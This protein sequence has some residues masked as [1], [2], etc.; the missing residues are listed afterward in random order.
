MEFL[1]DFASILALIGAV[2]ATGIFFVS[3]RSYLENWRSDYE[4]CKRE[5]CKDMAITKSN[6]YE[7]RNHMEKSDIHLTYMKKISEDS[8]AAVKEMSHVLDRLSQILESI[9]KKVDSWGTK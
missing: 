4:S 8:V 5:S 3:L 7:I 6:T 2:L 1:N 9:E